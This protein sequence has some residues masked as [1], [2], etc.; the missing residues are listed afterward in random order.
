MFGPN[1]SRIA[2][3]ISAMARHNPSRRPFLHSSLLVSQSSQ[4]IQ[5]PS[6]QQE[7]IIEAMNSHSYEKPHYA[8]V[9]LK[10]DINEEVAF[11]YL[12][13]V[14]LGD[15]AEV[16]RISRIEPPIQPSHCTGLCMG[17]SENVTTNLN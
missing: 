12:V 7:L 6:S 1:S 15:A 2:S 17:R 9:S 3:A 8:F 16:I 4:R 14:V 13:H 5:R 10:H 11:V